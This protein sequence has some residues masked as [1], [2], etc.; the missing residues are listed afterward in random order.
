MCVGVE[1]CAV[2]GTLRA[3]LRCARSADCAVAGSVARLIGGSGRGGLRAL[4]RM[5][6]DVEHTNSGG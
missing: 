2:G 6:C 4:D 3:G 1:V 5:V